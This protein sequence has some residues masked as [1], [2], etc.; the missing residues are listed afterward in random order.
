V[1]IILAGI[2]DNLHRNA[3]HNFHVIAGGVFRG[4]QTET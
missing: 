2:E 4:Q 3:L 1:I